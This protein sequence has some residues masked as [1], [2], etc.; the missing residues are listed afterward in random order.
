MGHEDGD[1]GMMVV[2]HTRVEALA[3]EERASN[4]P[5]AMHEGGEADGGGLKRPQYAAV[6]PN[7]MVRET[8]YPVACHCCVKGERNGLG[9]AAMWMAGAAGGE[10]ASR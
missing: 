1:N 2:D 10:S 9:A 5:G 6:N 3:A 4:D 7:E 8:R